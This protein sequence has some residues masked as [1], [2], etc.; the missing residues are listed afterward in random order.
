[1]AAKSD[2]R[3][4]PA[5][6]PHRAELV[7]SLT[8]EGVWIDPSQLAKTVENPALKS[9]R[10]RLGIAMRTPDRFAYDAINDAVLKVALSR[11]RQRVGGPSVRRFVRFLP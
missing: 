6:R 10:R 11:E 2:A 1:M 5:E 9:L 7:I 3:E 8:H 4:L